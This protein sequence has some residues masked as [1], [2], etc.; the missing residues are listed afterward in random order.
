[1]RLSMPR[2]QPEGAAQ[3]TLLQ[4]LIDG[5]AVEEE[6]A[7]RAVARQMFEKFRHRPQGLPAPP[8]GPGEIQP[9][10]TRTSEAPLAGMGA[11]L[12]PHA[13]RKV[14]GV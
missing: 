6:N 11:Q 12:A 5:R 9:R 13:C 3:A 4:V 7:Q 2:Q 8:E 10:A 1:V 14:R